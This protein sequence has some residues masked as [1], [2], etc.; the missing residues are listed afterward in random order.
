M[1][2]VYHLSNASRPSSGSDCVCRSYRVHMVP[3]RMILVK[4]LHIECVFVFVQIDAKP[5]GAKRH[6]QREFHRVLNT[7]QHHIVLTQHFCPG[8]S[9]SEME[10]S[11]D[12]SAVPDA[13]G[14]D[15]G[16]QRRAWRV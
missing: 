12:V 5:S 10:S 15:L 11:V 14:A 1:C 7:F 16:R 9:D 6:R 3:I 2:H 4:V 13:S 8:L